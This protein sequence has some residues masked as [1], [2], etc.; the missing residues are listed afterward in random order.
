MGLFSSI[1]ILLSRSGMSYINQRDEATTLVSVP[2]AI[3][4]LSCKRHNRQDCVV[5]MHPITQNA[6]LLLAHLFVVA[7]L[8][9]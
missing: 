7:M 6:T 9:W 2:V 1:K 5:T 3:R 8:Q 4:E